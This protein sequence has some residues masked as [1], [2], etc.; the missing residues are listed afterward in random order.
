MDFAVLSV[1]APLEKIGQN[2]DVGQEDG[3]ANSE[4]GEEEMEVESEKEEEKPKAGGAFSSALSS[5]N[6]LRPGWFL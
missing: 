3:T 5:L 2:K 4:H 6:V 1:E